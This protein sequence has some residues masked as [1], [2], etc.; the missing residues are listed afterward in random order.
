MSY[1]LNEDVIEVQRG[2]EPGGMG[3]AYRTFGNVETEPGSHS[4]GRLVLLEDG[5]VLSA[6]G[7]LTD[8]AG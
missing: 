2:P 8:Y 4:V 1:E 6:S 7:K 5:S 3:G